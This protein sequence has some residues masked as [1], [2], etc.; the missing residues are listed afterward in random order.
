MTADKGFTGYAPYFNEQ[1][2][3]NKNLNSHMFDGEGSTTWQDINV[4]WS[5]GS[6]G[7]AAAW[8]RG[9]DSDKGLEIIK[10]TAEMSVEG[11]LIYSSRN[12]PYLF[13]NYPSV[14][15]TAWFIIACELY[16]DPDTIFWSE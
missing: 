12:L 2:Y 13:S 6:L 10:N 15:G 16:K 8:I 1:V 9:G 7:A 3:E 4:V 11:G 5:E 14:A